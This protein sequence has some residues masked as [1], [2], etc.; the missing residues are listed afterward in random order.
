MD[1]ESKKDTVLICG[2]P[3][4]GKTTFLGALSYLMLSREIKTRL[5][6]AGLP[7]ERAYMNQLSDRWCQCETMERTRLNDENSMSINFRTSQKLL[8]INFPDLSGETWKYLWEDHKCS[9]ELANLVNVSTGIVVFIHADEVKKPM[10]VV[11]AQRLT[12][13]LGSELGIQKGDMEG[14]VED[15]WSSS[16]HP[17]TQAIIVALLQLLSDKPIGSPKNKVSIVLSAWDK[18]E[19][20]SPVDFL[21]MELPLLYQYLE[22]GF[23]YSN[24]KVF[25]VSAQG[26][27][28]CGSEGNEKDKLL[29]V[30]IPSSRIDVQDGDIRS[31]D[32]TTILEWTLV[33]D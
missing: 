12:D 5:E 16:E 6:H 25:G 31:S 1:I 32:L 18:V 22:G 14:I 11:H 3:N 21:K 17:P 10:S 23:D 27:D 28:L 19:G 2:L 4:S 26:G 20:F 8:E 24:W 13:A 15:I 30:E 33:H 29:A 7:K 9:K